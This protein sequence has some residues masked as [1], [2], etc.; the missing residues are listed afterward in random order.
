MTETLLNEVMPVINAIAFLGGAAVVFVKMI[1]TP[2]GA[3]SRISTGV[4][5]L[6]MIAFLVAGVGH[7]LWILQAVDRETYRLM[8]E[9]LAS[10]VVAPVF[11]G[12]FVVDKQ[13]AVI[14][15]RTNAEAARVHERIS[16]LEEQIHVD[17]LQTRM[18]QSE[19]RMSASEG[20]LTALE[21]DSEESK[22]G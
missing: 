5:I 1:S 16:Q 10:L 20:R 4:Y 6:V 21:S 13:V 12:F 7:L 17:Q 19:T 9:V 8:T 3:I 15:A 2:S 14:I 22:G 11:L 18:S